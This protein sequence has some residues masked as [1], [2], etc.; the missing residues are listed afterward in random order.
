VNLSERAYVGLH[1]HVVER[2]IK[3]TP[4]RDA[5]ILDVGCGTG[6]LLVRLRTLGYKNLYGID[7]DPP[8][9]QSGIEFIACDLDRFNDPIEA[10]TVDLAV[11]VEII[12]H[13]E[14]I[15]GL[16]QGLS[17]L[18]RPNGLI[19]LTTPNVHS[20][21]AKIR[22]LLTGS[23][24]QFDAIGDPTHVTPIFKFP[25]E[26]VLRRHGFFVIDSWGFPVDGSSLTSRYSTLMLANVARFL[27][28]KDAPAG[29]SLCM[30]VGRDSGSRIANNS[31]QKRDALTS[32]YTKSEKIVQRQV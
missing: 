14:N 21:E 13:I 30:L 7:I 6:A 16:L 10:G 23:L 22:Y 12:E 8:E 3:I 1:E 25:F 2:L 18:L 11:A 28:A 19:L 31:E 15:G 26:R 17:R 5:R 27:G 20:V 9:S 32:H 24:K 29:D 4:Q